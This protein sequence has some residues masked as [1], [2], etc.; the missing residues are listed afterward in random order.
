MQ[1][2]KNLVILAAGIGSRFRGGVKQ[3]HSV[4]PAGE[5]IMDYS[6]YDALEAGFNR[7]VFIIRKDIE[8]LF[9]E[10]VGKRVR[11]ICQDRG[12]EVVCVF[13]EKHDLPRGFICPNYRA[14]P[15]G[16]G[17]ALLRCKGALNGGFVVIN[18][19]D[20]Y[21]KDA[22]RLMSEFLDSLD[23]DAQGVYA[24][25]GFLLSNTLS[26][27]GGVTRGL[28]SVDE[29][30][31]LTHIQET[32]K[33][34]KTDQGPGVQTTN[35]M[36][37]FDGTTSVSMNM[38][39]FTPDILDRLENQFISFLSYGGL[40]TPNSEFLIPTQIGAMLDDGVAVKVIPTPGK[41]FGMTFSEEVPAVQTA[42][43]QMTQEGI[44]PS[45]LFEFVDGSIPMVGVEAKEHA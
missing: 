20:Y 7:I 12:V 39:A 6:I 30:G 23:E 27:H 44:Y 45:P 10:L 13:Q 1:S 33:I 8:A 29:E 2:E 36:H 43:S 22:Y 31:N 37:Y 16:T 38:W 28:C 17:Q 35:G 15:W 3:L 24:M 41:W 26:E 14:K 40:E 21:G 25:A 18:A 32:K 4:G 11:Q 5:C 42:F 34:L 9:E 19:D